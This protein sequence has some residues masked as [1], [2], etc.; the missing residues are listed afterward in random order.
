M[1]PHAASVPSVPFGCAL[2]VQRDSLASTLALGAVATSTTRAGMRRKVG[3]HTLASSHS[4]KCCVSL[5][6]LQS[7]IPLSD[8]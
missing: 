6:S 4:M 2:Q 1:S 7:S 5:D 8:L 3:L